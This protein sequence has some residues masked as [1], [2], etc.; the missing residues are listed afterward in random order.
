MNLGHL[1]CSSATICQSQGPDHLYPPRAPSYDEALRLSAHLRLPHKP[2]CTGQSGSNTKVKTPSGRG[3][4]I[5]GP[6]PHPDGGTRVQTPSDMTNTQPD[7]K[8]PP[9]FGG[10]FGG[11]LGGMLG[12]AVGP[13]VWMPRSHRSRITSG[14]QT[15]NRS[16]LS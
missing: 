3:K 15:G 11:M 12:V 4:Q 10:M 14:R 8:Q 5:I 13:R 6:H 7:Y 2:L 9:D 1:L 16:E